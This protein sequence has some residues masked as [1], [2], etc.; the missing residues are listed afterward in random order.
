M[1]IYSDSGY[2]YG[3]GYGEQMLRH[4]STTNWTTGA[5]AGFPYYICVMTPVLVAPPSGSASVDILDVYTSGHWSNS[6]WGEIDVNTRY[7]GSGLQKYSFSCHRGPST[8]LSLERERGYE[9][10]SNPLTVS[11]TTSGSGTHGG[12]S[13]YRHRFTM[14]CSAY[15]H[16]QA[17]IRIGLNY[18][19]HTTLFDSASSVANVESNRNSSGAGVHF[20]NSSISGH[21]DRD[22]A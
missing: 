2:L 14:S 3:S 10:P 9:M 20:L 21:P 19:N 12:Q 13:V 4:G 16:I 5:V 6:I 22:T 8:T 1:A 18:D 15:M 11:T 17:I 7:Y